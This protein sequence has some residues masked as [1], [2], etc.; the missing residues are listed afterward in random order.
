MSNSEHTA[1][2]AT[3]I[4]RRSPIAIEVC[5]LALAVERIG[6][7]WSL[8]ILREA[9]YGVMRYDDMRADLGI[10][11]SVLTDRL[12]RLVDHGL[13]ERRPYREPG[14]RQRSAYAL[15]AAGRDLA[16]GFA[17]LTLWADRHVLEGRGPV[18]I[19]DTE[20]GGRLTAML[21]DADGKAVPADRAT[22]RP[23]GGDGA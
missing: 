11:R 18:E 10:P 1:A 9:F 15:T 8:L 4:R 17:A 22:A 12:N 19:V 7:R 6:D 13:L 2:T 14:E 3:G 5:P 16:V 23:R 21:V 20:T